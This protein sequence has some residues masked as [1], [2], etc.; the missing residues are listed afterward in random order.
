MT[1]K[2][3]KDALADLPEK[4]NN[5]NVFFRTHKEMNNGYSGLIDHPIVGAYVPDEEDEF[6]L[7]DDNAE[8]FL[9]LIGEKGF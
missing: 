5:L 9:R 6:L 8:V 2:E 7:I 1:V 3:F 4:Y